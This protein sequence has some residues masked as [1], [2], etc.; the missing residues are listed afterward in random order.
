MGGIG[1][2]WVR[3]DFELG[4]IFFYYRFTLVRQDCREVLQIR[5]KIVSIALNTVIIVI[6]YHDIGLD[7]AVDVCKV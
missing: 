2:I 4:L 6:C 1:C 7:D 5:L 3:E